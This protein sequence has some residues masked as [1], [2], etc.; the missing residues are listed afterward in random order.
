[1]YS[2]KLADILNKYNNEHH[3]TIKLKPVEVKSSTY[4][5]FDKKITRKILHLLGRSFCDH[6]KLKTLCRGYM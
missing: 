6:K 3:T 2:D 4:I 5:E 1:M